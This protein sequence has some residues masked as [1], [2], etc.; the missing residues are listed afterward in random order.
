AWSA[1]VGDVAP[2][3]GASFTR[4][5]WTLSPGLRADAFPVEGSRVLPPVGITP[6]AGFSRLTWALDPRLSLA[7]A[8]APG[9]ILNA[10]AGGPHQPVGPMDLSAVFG[11]PDLAPAR[12]LHAVLSAWRRL[13][14][15]TSLE[16]TAFFRRLEGLTVRSPL[17]VP[18]LA[19]A[20][21]SDGRG[22]SFG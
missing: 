20:L 12:A 19:G 21:V 1:T 6:Q 14:A 4:G 10:A 7:W 9:F 18:P 8:P 16:A 3:L 22:R 2:Y 15:D 11:A 5:A 13:G 17:P